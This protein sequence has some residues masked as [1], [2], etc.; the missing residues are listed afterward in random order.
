M[1]MAETENITRQLERLFEKWS[2]RPPRSVIPLPA[3]GSYRQYYRIRGEE[4]SVM[5]M[6]NGDLKENDSF[7][8]IGEQLRQAGC[9]VPLILAS[10]P[11]KGLYLETDLGDMTLLD[12]LKTVREEENGLLKTLDIYK[13]VIDCMPAL[14]VEGGRGA[15]YSRCHPRAEFDAQS[16]MW[17]M[18][19][20]KYCLLKPL[21]IR[22]HEQDLETDFRLILEHL[23]EAPRDHF[24]YRDFQS[25]NIMLHEGKLFFIDFQGG[26]KGPLQYDLASLLYEA[27]THLGEDIREQLLGYYLEVFEKRYPWFSRKQFLSRYYGFVYLRLMQ[28]M[29]AYGFRGF[30]EHKPLFLESLPY[31]AGI[32]NALLVSHPLPLPLTC[33]PDSAAQLSALYPERH[34]QAQ[35]DRLTVTV[36][37]FSYRSGIP[38]DGSGHGGGFVFDCRALTNPGRL[39]EF[40]ALT[41]KDKAVAD[42]LGD[43]DDMK[44]FMKYSFKLVEQAVGV[45]QLRR[46]SS[47]MVCFGC[48]GGRHRS[49]YV[50]DRLAEFLA[51]NYDVD[52]VVRHTEIDKNP[53]GA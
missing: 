30:T 32:L 13:R 31:A 49:V 16:M 51:E 45:Y 37:S 50:A 14:Q 33:L 9:N 20:F 29:G 35:G 6:Y 38:V 8:A 3:S 10:E 26:R 46:F 47:L 40:A 36:C 12:Y 41:G 22:F 39:D 53:P 7:V 24:M 27:K 1:T 25:R 44:S 2:G 48:T 52:V 17:D 19:Y 5:G 42:F 15:D 28:A 21:K 18:N 4:G 34:R 23:L 11:E 43:R